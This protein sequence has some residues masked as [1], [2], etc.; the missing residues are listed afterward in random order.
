[1]MNGIQAEFS[2]LQD[3]VTRI[4]SKNMAAAKFNGLYLFRRRSGDPV[5]TGDLVQSGNIS[6]KI[7]RTPYTLA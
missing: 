6:I 3:E 7:G 5:V 2:A 1:M 4:T